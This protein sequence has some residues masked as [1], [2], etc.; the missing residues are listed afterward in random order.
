MP[1]PVTPGWKTAAMVS[2]TSLRITCVF[3]L[4][5]IPRGRMVIEF[6]GR[7][8]SP[9]QADSASEART[10]YLASLADGRAIDPSVGGSG[11]EFVNHS[12]NPN[13]R[14]RRIRGR[15]FFFSRRR[16]R[17]GK[18]LSVNYNYPKRIRRIPCR[19]GARGC[20]GTLRYYIL[21]ST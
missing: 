14:W 17:A 16:I 7:R 4:E 15:L 21:P 2:Q 1:M 10:I 9:R 11:A 5:E 6:T 12:C 13:L 19:C 3:A 18:E 8:L 20:S